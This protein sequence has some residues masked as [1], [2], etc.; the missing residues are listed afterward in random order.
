MPAMKRKAASTSNDTNKFREDTN[1]TLAHYSVSDD[2]DKPL[3]GLVKVKEE[4]DF[5]DNTSIHFYILRLIVQ[6][7]YFSTI[8]EDYQ[9]VPL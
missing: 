4:I 1:V 7:L 2:V 6:F 3:D 8:S 5:S 9:C